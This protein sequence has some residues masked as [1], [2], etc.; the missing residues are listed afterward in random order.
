LWWFQLLSSLPAFA[1]SAWADR[2]RDVMV[3]FFS[4]YRSA[5]V[6]LVLLFGLRRL[7][8]DHSA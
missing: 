6:V 5:A 2:L 4:V 3:S 7:D 8:S 1:A